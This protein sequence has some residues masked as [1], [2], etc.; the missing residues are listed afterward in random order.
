MTN[1]FVQS[2]VDIRPFTEP[3]KTQQVPLSEFLLYVDLFHLI[4]AKVDQP[5]EYYPGVYQLG[6][7]MKREVNT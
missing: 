6:I 1:L 4:S 3:S 5:Y 7:Q 2:T